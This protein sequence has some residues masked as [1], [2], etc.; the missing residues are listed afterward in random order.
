MIAR[1]FVDSNIL[2]YAHD[3]AAGNK[4]TEAISLLQSLWT[5]RQGV[6]SVQVLQEVFV[7]VTRK[8]HKPLPAHIAREIIETYRLWVYQPTGAE[9]ILHAIDLQT[10]LGF[11]FWDSLI[12]TSALEAECEW[13]YSEDLQHGQI[14]E[15]RLRIVNPFVTP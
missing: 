2:I 3:T 9:T 5:T 12:V 11:S 15:Q 1:A 10:R 4:H 6:L 13:L 8:I 14:I 7:N